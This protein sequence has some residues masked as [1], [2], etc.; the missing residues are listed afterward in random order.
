MNKGLRSTV[1]AL[2]VAASAA[3]LLQG[4][5]PAVAT[6]V[7]AG[8]MMAADRRTSGAYVED[9]GIEWKA[10]AK[11]KEKLGDL[12]HVNVTSYNRNVLLTGE[13]PNETVKDQLPGIVA[14]VPNIRGITS[15][16]QVAGHSSLTSRSNDALIT[17]KVKA[18]MIDSDAVQA[19]LI[20]VVT[21]A[22]TVYLMGLVTRAEADA[23]TQVARTTSGVKKVV[24]VFEYVSPE[25]AKRLDLLRRDQ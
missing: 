23:A 7:G 15:D 16:V 3:P 24:R 13:A 9:E 25:E 21:E 4:C 17:S 11:I 18:R 19:H 20:K 1:L 2:V 22:S 6:G 12:V 10:A 8:A 14:A 5:F